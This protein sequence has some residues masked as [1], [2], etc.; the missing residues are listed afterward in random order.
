V[1]GKALVVFSGG[2]DSTTI[3]G[4]A[5]NRFND[6][7]TITFGYGQRHKIEIE[8]AKKI[9]KILEVPNIYF[10]FDL[11]KKMGDSTLVGDGDLNAPHPHNPNLP[12]SY[13]PNRNALMFT[14]AHAYAQKIGAGNLIT[15]VCQTDYSGY[16]DCRAVFIEALERTLNLGSEESIKFHSPLMYLNK[17]ET[18]ALA[19]KEGVLGIVLEHSHTCYEGDRAHRFEWGYGCGICPSCNLRKRGWEEFSNLSR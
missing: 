2:Q 9:A 14:I 5:K 11:F 1:E 6:V 10:E 17:A 19:E 12:S 3:L 4:W 18:F 7:Y 8:Q 13:V 15:G 16:P